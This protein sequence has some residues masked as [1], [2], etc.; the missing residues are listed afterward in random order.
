MIAYRI[1]IAP[2]DNGTLLLTCPAF[3]EVATFGP[4]APDQLLSIARAAIEEAIAARIS[5]GEAVPRAATEV[6][7]KRHKGLY[8]KLPFQSS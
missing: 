5:D 7:R 4:N 2:D 1:K 6:E 3:P 8:V